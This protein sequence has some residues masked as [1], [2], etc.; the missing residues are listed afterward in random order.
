MKTIC[1]HCGQVADN[2]APGNGCHS[3]N[4]GIMIRMP[5]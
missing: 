4:K 1:T 2:Q 3:C 5:E